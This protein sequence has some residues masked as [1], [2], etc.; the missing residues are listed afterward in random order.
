MRAALGVRAKADCFVARF[1]KTTKGKPHY[2]QNMSLFVKV[3]PM[4]NQEISTYK[5][6]M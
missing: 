6:I 3:K 5:T 2:T 1:N 4:T